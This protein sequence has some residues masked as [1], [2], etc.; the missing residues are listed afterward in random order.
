MNV[1]GSDLALG[2]TA[3]DHSIEITF[4]KLKLKYIVLVFCVSLH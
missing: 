4:K 2:R 1:V 3:M